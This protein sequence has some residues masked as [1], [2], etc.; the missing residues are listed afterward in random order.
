MESSGEHS[1]ETRPF[2]ARFA[3]QRTSDPGLPGRYC[4]EREQWVIDTPEGPVAL[5]NLTHGHMATE[6]RVGGEAS[7]A[8]I[9]PVV[10]LATETSVGG[11]GND[12][13]ATGVPAAMGTLTEAGNEQLDGPA[14]DPF[15]AMVTVTKVQGEQTDS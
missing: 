7:D 14:A 13:S 5:A 2:L 12:W 3:V 9:G 6:T 8:C 1:S 10:A 11:E 15:L 4:D